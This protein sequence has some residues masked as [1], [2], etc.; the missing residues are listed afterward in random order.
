MK[1]TLSKDNQLFSG[2]NL[3]KLEIE[4]RGAESDLIISGL[5]ENSHSVMDGNVFYAL[6]GV[7]YHG[8]NFFSKAVR[9][10]AKL[11]IT[12]HQGAKIIKGHGYSGLL[13][14]TLNPRE[15]LAFHSSR[16]Y[17]G[18]P[19]NQVAV[20][21]TNGKTSVCNFLRQ[22]WEQ[23]DF[24][25][26]NIGTMGVDG[27]F[28]KTLKH[29][30]PDPVTLHKLLR[31]LNEENIT[32]VAMEASSH[33]L[34]QYRLDGVNLSGAAFTNLSRDHL[35]YHS[36]EK[37]YFKSK[38]RL[39]T[40]ILPAT[41]K[42]VINID[43]NWGNEI[44]NLVYHR[45]LDIM[46]IGKSEAADIKLLD[47][48][49]F[50]DGQKIKFSFQNKI[51]V[52][53][54]NLVGSFQCSNVLIAAGLAISLGQDPD[55][56][57]STL[58]N[59]KNIPGR[60][61]LVAKKKCGAQIYVDYAHTPGA[62]QSILTDIR[63]HVFGRI[64]VLFGAGGDRDKGKRFLMG[65]IA[66]QLA[67]IVFVTD[68]N[69]RKEDPSSIRA[70]ILSGCQNAIEIADRAEA[71]V[72]AVDCIKSE[73]VLIIAGKGHETGQIIGSDYFPFNDA[74]VANTAVSILGKDYYDY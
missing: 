50:S 33:G 23:L 63:P 22:I 70:E 28:S 2:L 62:L 57:F 7:N 6:P 25:S 39:F 15:I 4:G 49:F 38:K 65:K 56:V 9:R 5:T 11:I 16:F 36:N 3:E 45:G 29:T 42:V 68:D 10:G 26:V 74:E 43:T 54:L 1:I 48:K 31:H 35:D 73:D 13:C 19:K 17:S 66:T 30:S 40:E 53:T 27:S 41:G 32:H 69:P 52:C 51:E 44:H 34:D 12:D 20:T 14:R 72:R 24:R 64:C 58:P 71:I 61:E 55:E 46:R 60:M 47:Q 37:N 21:G 18:Q 67:D 8:A 59:L